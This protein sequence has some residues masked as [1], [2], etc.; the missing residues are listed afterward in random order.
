MKFIRLMMLAHETATKKTILDIAYYWF[1]KHI[2][3]KSQRMLKD[4]LIKKIKEIVTENK[5]LHRDIIETR[6][7]YMI[8]MPR[9]SS[10]KTTTSI[11]CYI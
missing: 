10:F 9:A 5:L 7:Y 1:I 11:R 2:N 6:T 8:L 3:P 4:A